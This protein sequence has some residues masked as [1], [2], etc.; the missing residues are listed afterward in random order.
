[1]TRDVPVREVMDREYVAASESDDALETA[2]L[3]LR[4]GA[5]PVVVLRGSEPVG[6][7]TDRDLLALLV[8]RDADPASETVGTAMTESVPTVSPEQTLAEVRDEMAARG[9]PWLVVS[10]G[11]EPAGVVTEHHVLTGSALG[12]ER[13]A[14]EMAAGV[15][16]QTDVEM[17][18][19][20]ATEAASPGTEGFEEQSICEQ[21]GSLSRDLASFNGQLLCADC[22]DI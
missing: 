2:E 5:E 10:D 4:E 17:T 20:T 7:L 22:R 6:V 14:T 12:A 9:S 11:G 1:M 21:C 16:V 18:N 13:D 8:D 19:A 15:N 3:M